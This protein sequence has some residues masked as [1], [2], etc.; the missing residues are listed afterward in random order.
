M[1]RV[2]PISRWESA[3]AGARLFVTHGSWI[4]LSVVLCGSAFAAAPLTE[5]WVSFDG[6]TATPSPPE[7][8][9]LSSGTSELMVE[10]RVP[11]VLCTSV[12]EDEMEFMKLDL[13][14]YD[15]S[16]EVDQATFVL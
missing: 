15:R 5:G 9:V 2:G 4:A 16:G 6:V 11:G 13:P 3:S 7:L 14:G 12:V 10:I 8:H 1:T